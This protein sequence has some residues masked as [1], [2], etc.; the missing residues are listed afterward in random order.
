[1]SDE[2]NKSHSFWITA[3][4]VGVPV[5]YVTSFGPACWITSRFDVRKPLGF[6]FRPVMLMWWHG[7]PPRQDDALDRYSRLAAAPGWGMGLD[8]KSGAYD[9]GPRP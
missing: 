6:V 7:Q 1:M 8:V 9:W 4:L 5:L 3:L 2:R